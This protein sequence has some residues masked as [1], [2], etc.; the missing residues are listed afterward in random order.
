MSMANVF[1]T[2]QKTVITCNV[3]SEYAIKSQIL[4]N[5]VSLLK[6]IDKYCVYTNIKTSVRSKFFCIVI[7]VMFKLIDFVDV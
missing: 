5:K 2:E 3:Y 4:V 1:S 7:C 6:R